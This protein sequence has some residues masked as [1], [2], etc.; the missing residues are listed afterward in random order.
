VNV[1]APFAWF[2]FAAWSFSL[3]YM[4]YPLGN[5]GML[6]EDIRDYNRHNRMRSLGLGTG[7]FLL[8]SIPVINFLAMPVAV[9]AATRLTT[10]TIDNAKA[11][12]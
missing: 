2:V 8:T 11:P 3:E 5:R 12:R 6:F 9:C 10:R 4:D 1:I 7:V